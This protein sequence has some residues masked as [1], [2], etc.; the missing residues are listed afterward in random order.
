MSP[1]K[2]ET[3]AQIAKMRDAPS[4][5]VRVT[6]WSAYPDGAQ[7]VPDHPDRDFGFKIIPSA[8]ARLCKGL[9]QRLNR[10]HPHPEEGIPTKTPTGF[11]ACAQVGQ[12]PKV[13]PLQWSVSSKTRLPHHDAPRVLLAGRSEF[14]N[15][16]RRMLAIG[17][18]AEYVCKL[19][20]KCHLCTC[21]NGC[22]LAPIPPAPDHSEP[23]SSPKNRLQSLVTPIRA[24]IHQQ[25][26]LRVKPQ[27]RPQGLL[28][29]YPWV[30]GGHQNHKSH[31]R[32]H[33]QQTLGPLAN[34][35]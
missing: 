4:C 11:Q 29:Q 22:T 26:D 2:Q 24:A 33:S 32:P 6:Y 31:F 23:R 8:V 21:Q 18:E 7:S 3:V 12:P 15:Q 34:R 28:Q 10:V 25:P 1:H 14:G 35:R 16:I 27:N 19:L 30:V 9:K 17:I 13:H 5:G 20:C